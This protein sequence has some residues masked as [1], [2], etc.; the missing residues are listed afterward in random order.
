MITTTLLPLSAPISRRASFRL[1]WQS[2]SARR[3]LLEK[4]DALPLEG[5]LAKAISFLHTRIGMETDGKSLGVGL[6]DEVSGAMVVNLG[7]TATADG[8]VTLPLYPDLAMED[9]ALICS[10]IRGVMGHE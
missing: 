3:T 2:P 1:T 6:R 7:T 4:L 9:V 10:V 8:V 5:P